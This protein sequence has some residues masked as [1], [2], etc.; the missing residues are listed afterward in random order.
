[1][2]KN[3]ALLTSFKWKKLVVA[4]FLGHPGRRT[5]DHHQKCNKWLQIRAPEISG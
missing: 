3:L 2:G 4:N 1:M 5:V